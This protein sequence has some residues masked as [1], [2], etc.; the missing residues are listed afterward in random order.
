MERWKTRESAK[1]T[2]HDLDH[3][4]VSIQRRQETVCIYGRKPTL[5]N[6]DGLW[7]T[8]RARCVDH[9]ERIMS[10]VLESFLVS[11]LGNGAFSE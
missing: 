2:F 1:G 10:R 7:K 6:N 9:N 11:V 5:T 4:F 8:G 3:G